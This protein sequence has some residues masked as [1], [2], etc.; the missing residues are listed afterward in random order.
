MKLLRSV[1]RLADLV[2]DVR[3]TAASDFLPDSLPL[4]C[5]ILLSH[6]RN[7]EIHDL[8]NAVH[9]SSIQLAAANCNRERIE[10]LILWRYVGTGNKPFGRCPD[11]IIGRSTR[12]QEADVT[13][14]VVIKTAE[15]NIGIGYSKDP[16]NPR[17]ESC[18]P[19]SAI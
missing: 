18:P 7:K 16:K 6:A 9:P 10:G 1:E 8:F 13:N 19:Y 2:S 5:E 3:V 4:L 12:Y 11:L 17:I 14:S 15:T